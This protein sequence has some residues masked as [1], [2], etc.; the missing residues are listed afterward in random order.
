MTLAAVPARKKARSSALDL[1][2]VRHEPHEEIADA[3]RCSTFE[4]KQALPVIGITEET[5]AALADGDTLT[6]RGEAEGL[7]A[8]LRPLRHNSIRRIGA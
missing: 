4:D 6:E 3:A 7:Q 5:H 1:E 8:P 2:H